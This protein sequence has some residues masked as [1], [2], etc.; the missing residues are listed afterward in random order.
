MGWTKFDGSKVHGTLARGD[1]TMPPTRWWN[2]LFL[3]W[4]K[5]DKVTVFEVPAGVIPYRVG[6][7]PEVGPAMLKEDLMSS[8]RFAV[9]NGHEDCVFYAV[10]DTG[11]EIILLEIEQISADSLPAN[12][13]LI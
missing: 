7:K 6:Y 8:R 13:P 11:K 1:K 5:W 10:D 12:I 2:H 4:F 3:L 9:R